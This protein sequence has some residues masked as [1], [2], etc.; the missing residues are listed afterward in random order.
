MLDNLPLP[1]KL[2]AVKFNL[3]PSTMADQDKLV[4]VGSGL[5]LVEPMAQDD[6]LQEDPSLQSNPG[7]ALGVAAAA[8]DLPPH[9]M[10]PMEDRTIP[11]GSAPDHGGPAS[12]ASFDMRQMLEMLMQKMD[13]NAQRADANARRVDANAQRMDANMQA[14]RDDMQTLRGEMQSTGISLQEQMKAGQEE[15]KAELIKVKG[16]MQAMDRKMAD[17]SGTVHGG[18][19]RVERECERCL[20]RNGNG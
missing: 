3:I 6:T 16:E 13:V 19:Y 5:T 7:V 1:S 14:Q 17:E 15:M 18:N 11:V 8:H 20:V 12:P 10:P 9:Q 2:R 4:Q